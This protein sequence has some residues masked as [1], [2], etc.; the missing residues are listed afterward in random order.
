[1]K[2]THAI[3]L[4]IASLLSLNANAQR[5]INPIK[6]TASI[7]IDGHLNEEDWLKSEGTAQF[8]N[9]RPNPGTDSQHDTE[10]KVL[11]DDQS[12]Y[13]S[14]FLKDSSRDSIMTQ[15]TE[16]DDIGNADFFLVFID[17]YKG[18]NDATQFVLAS[19]GVQMDAKVTTNHEEDWGWDAIWDG[20]VQLT[21]KGWYVEM[22]IPY[23]S[24][25][26]S[27]KDIQEWNINFMR[28]RAST[29]EQSCW[30]PIDLKQDNPTLTQMGALV[31]LKDIRPPLRLS[32]SPY[33]SLYGI[34]SKDASRIPVTST[35]TSYNG[36]MDVK[37]GI[38]EA[39]TLDMTL[40][41]D[42]GQV[43]SDDQVLNLSPFE[44]R[45]DENRPFFTEGGEFFQKGGIFYS[46]R[47]G[48]VPLKYGDAYNNLTDQE[49]VIENPLNAQLYN[50]TKV[51]GR[52]AKGL[53]LGFFNAVAASSHATIENKTTGETRQVKTSPLSNYNV[54]ILDQNL[55]NNSSVSITNTNVWRQGA[56]FYDANVTAVTM[57]LKDKNQKFGLSTNTSYS[58]QSFADVDNVTGHALE[59]DLQRLDG[60]LVYGLSYE[61]ISD[62]YDSNDLGFLSNNNERS[63][64]AN[65]QYR[66]FD[67]FWK[68]NQFQSWLNISHDRL[69]RSNQ[70]A[71]THFNAGFWGQ[72]SGLWNVNMWFNYRPDSYD[73]FEP[74]REGWFHKNPDMMN[75]GFWFGSDSRKPFRMEVFG[76]AYNMDEEGR[77]GYEFGVEPRIRISDQLTLSAD[78]QF[79]KELRGKGW[80][81]FGSGDEI[82]YSTR[83][84]TTISNLVGL[85]YSVNPNMSFNVRVRH[86]WSKVAHLE[87]LEL[88]EDGLFQTTDYNTN[89][90]LSFN[91]FTTDAVFRWRFAPGSDLF[92]VWKNNIN[93]VHQQADVN[94]ET[95][96]YFTG[97]Q[98]LNQF[99]QNNSLS[100]RAVFYLDYNRLVSRFGA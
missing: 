28:R 3:L 97:L 83:D 57:N 49:Q 62:D 52:N 1:M 100:V 46:R 30:N 85:N 43:Q 11:Y 2:L 90:N 14:A 65:L 93:G 38:N 72:T 34:H 9:I 66:R 48:G 13:I 73:H 69:Y 27:K 64:S 26:F 33:V 78:A 24:I 53:G 84:R 7:D 82:I 17:T 21:D 35:G 54:F 8:T 29:G 42:F 60:Q 22:E 88:M 12:L 16:R 44:V 4:I 89:K 79:E 23:S 25:R 68:L 41:P 31:N 76:F 55:K 6:T 87:Y 70:Y 51:S 40:I 71:N 37:W 15:L 5:T 36:G 45:F 58:H 81:D 61:E 56:E 67:G 80:V 50:A 74:R 92:V 75:A 20:A 99:P 86:Y 18:G 47:I 91:S 95:L 39:L 32:F 59:I 94:Y 98:H 19:T 96:D 77:Y 63:Y 10:V